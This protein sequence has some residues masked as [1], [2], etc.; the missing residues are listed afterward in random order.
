[1]N[2]GPKEVAQ[3]AIGKLG[4]PPDFL[5]GDVEADAARESARMK[6]R[7]QRLLRLAA[8][9]DKQHEVAMVELRI[10]RSTL[11]AADRL[12]ARTLDEV[13]DFRTRR[14]KLAEQASATEWTLACAEM[15][16]QVMAAE[17]AG[18]QRALAAKRIDTAVTSE[19][20]M[21][22]ERKQMET[23]LDGV[24]RQLAMQQIRADQSTL[25]ESFRQ[26]TFRRMRS[27][28]K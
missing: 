15:E 27:L 4:G 13:E 26:L 17:R 23:V 22:R 9:R 11:L 10:A 1:M 14:S 6:Q 24:R 16:L 3:Q 8:L 19:S 2:P 20:I 25:D 7:E 12:M 28:A 5:G 21:N 18:V